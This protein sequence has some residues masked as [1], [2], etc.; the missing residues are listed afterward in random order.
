MLPSPPQR[1]GDDGKSPASKIKPV[2]RDPEK[3]RQQNIEAQKSYREKKKKRLEHLEM[4]AALAVD[5]N[6]SSVASSAGIGTQNT[7]TIHGIPSHNI[8][9]IDQQMDP[10]DL[11]NFETASQETATTDPCFALSDFAFTSPSPGNIAQWEPAALIDPLLQLEESTRNQQWASYLN[12][13]CPILHV[14]V[15]SSAGSKEYRELREGRKEHTRFPP[16]PCASIL[17]VERHCI[18]Q[19][20]LSI[21][22]H[23]GITEDMFCDEH[24][25]SPFFRPTG[26]SLNDTGENSSVVE[27]VQSIFKVLKQDVR[28]IREQITHLHRPMIDALPFPTFRKNLII[29]GTPIDEDEFFH[30]LLNGLVCWGRAGVGRRDYDMSTGH[31][32]TG[33]PW[34]CRSWEGRTWFLRKYWT[35]LG[36]EEGELVRQSEWWRSTRGE[37]EDLCRIIISGSIGTAIRPYQPISV[38]DDWSSLHALNTAKRRPHIILGICFARAIG[39]F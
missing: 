36:G 2:R 33:T 20:V 26:R 22:A 39:N 32:S 3:R 5:P 8:T 31:V 34:D 1:H 17:R 9:N 21:C 28:P 37:E 10:S 30:D 18:V 7:S 11:L 16:D 25:V 13:G 15:I 6:D 19:A 14:Q 4:L 12:C 35:M 29:T 38:L 23:I 24:A 27:K